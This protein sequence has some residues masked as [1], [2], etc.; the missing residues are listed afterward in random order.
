MSA[1]PTLLGALDGLSEKAVAVLSQWSGVVFLILYLY[2][3]MKVR[4]GS[5]AVVS[6]SKRPAEIHSSEPAKDVCIR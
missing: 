6:Q 1:L 4:S 3:M 5:Q 2:W